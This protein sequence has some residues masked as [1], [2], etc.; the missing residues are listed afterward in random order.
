MNSP[1]ILA[2]VFALGT[3]LGSFLNVV[4][5]R[6]PR[7]QSLVR[8]GSHCPRCGTPVRPADNIPLLSFVLLRGRC[9]TC[10]APIGW[11]YPLVEATAGVLL[12]LIWS[13]YAP[14]GAWLALVSGAVLALS[15]L[16][17]FFIDLDHQ[18]VP[19]AITYPGLAAGLALSALQGRIVPAVVAAAGAGAFFLLIALVSRGGMGGGDIKLAAMMGAF[20]GWPGI[21]VGLLVG[22]LV[23]AAAGLVLMA[24]RKRSRKDPIPFGPA[25]AVGGVVALLAGDV[26][27]RWWLS[28]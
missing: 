27:L 8:P 14:A 17:V 21:A 1:A 20:L 3:I 10:R 28:L 13:S 15:L 25:L 6:L 26:L 7:K 12:V 23:G 22:F 18:I 24:A 4:I 2:F 9:R 11:R 5:Y 16:A 19:N